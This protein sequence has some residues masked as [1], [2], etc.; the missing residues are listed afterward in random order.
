MKFVNEDHLSIHKQQ[1]VSLS[2]NSSN[3]S[4][5]PTYIADETPTPTRFIRNCE[6]VGLFQDLQ[7]V[8]PFDEQF[9]RASEVVPIPTCT[10]DNGDDVLHTPQVFPIESESA[11]TSELHNHKSSNVRKY[12]LLPTLSTSECLH[13]PSP[14]PTPTPIVTITDPAS[15]SSPSNLSVNGKSTAIREVQ[16]KEKYKKPL[17]QSSSKPLL[18]Q[19]ASGTVNIMP[20]PTGSLP[21]PPVHD[22]LQLLF[23]LP[24]GR[25]VQIPAVP[26]PTETEPSIVLSDSGPVSKPVLSETKEK[27]KQVLSKAKS[28]LG[29]NWY[30]ATSS[31]PDVSETITNERAAA[32][33]TGMDMEM[34]MD[35]YGSKSQKSSTSDG[36]RS[37]PSSS[38]QDQD[39]T[40]SERRHKF[41]ER[42]RAAAMRSR[43]KRKC[44]VSNLE[45]RMMAV[46]NAN[47]LLQNEVLTLRSELAE[48]KLQLLA[49]KD[50]SVT[51]ALMQQARGNN[52]NPVPNPTSVNNPSVAQ[53]S[54]SSSFPTTSSCLTY[55]ND[56]TI[57][58]MKTSVITSVKSPD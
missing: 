32:T 15:S 38:E 12:Y 24:D 13:L 50:C 19:P 55:P 37:F 58:G 28:N 30:C 17:P 22:P 56:N 5:T 18:I 53:H 54:V 52:M 33:E 36:Q 7:H 31:K 11:L 8:N 48:L 40:E 42:N 4:K 45:T 20:R 34:L 43:Q 46:N 10:N 35:A 51:L 57:Y 23:R 27:L 29:P 41:L 6:E 49:H 16:R 26:V 2:I 14:L 9:R 39:D 1:H 3:G 25:L 47:K 21:S 44:W